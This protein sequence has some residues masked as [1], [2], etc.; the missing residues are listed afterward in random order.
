MVEQINFYKAK[1]KYEIDSW[2]LFDKLNSKE[3][4]VVID[5]RSNE[6]FE[7]GH[8]PEA[9]NI[10]HRTMNQ[11][12][13]GKLDKNIFTLPTAMKLDATPRPKER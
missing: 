1:L 8:I 4:V 13:Y 5:T 2:D 11:E 3:Q 9:I 7:R 10:S 12:T 6:A